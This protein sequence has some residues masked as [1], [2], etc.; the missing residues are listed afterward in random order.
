MFSGPKYS[1]IAL[2][3]STHSALCDTLPVKCHKASAFLRVAV[4]VAVVAV[5][6]AVVAVVTV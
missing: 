3:E 2:A 4:V 1:R 6:V 5:G